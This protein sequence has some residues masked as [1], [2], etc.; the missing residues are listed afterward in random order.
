M[1]APAEAQFK[2]R[3]L[4]LPASLQNVFLLRGDAVQKELNLNDEQKTTLTDLA[5][6]IATR[7]LGDLFRPAGPDARGAEGSRCP[8]SWR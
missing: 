3:G 7:R 5:H 1:A 6:A 8:K 4:Q 2:L